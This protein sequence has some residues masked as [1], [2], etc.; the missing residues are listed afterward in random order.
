MAMTI[1]PVDDGL[2]LVAVVLLGLK[3]V[4]GPIGLAR[5]RRSG[6]VRAAVDLGGK[7]IV[8]TFAGL[9]G[10]GQVGRMLVRPRRQQMVLAGH[11]ENPV[12]FQVFVGVN[13]PA[14][15]CVDRAGS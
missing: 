9:T 6:W 8:D 11:L 3:V 10:Q 4:R 1:D 13:R 2:N 14:S 5:I 12:F 15:L 7:V